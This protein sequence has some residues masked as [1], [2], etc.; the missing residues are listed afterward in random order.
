M[1]FEVFDGNISLIY[2][3]YLLL[4]NINFTI[5]S[6]EDNNNV[7]ETFDSIRKEET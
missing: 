4:L 2:L 3:F 1:Y 7:D 5:Q 6:D